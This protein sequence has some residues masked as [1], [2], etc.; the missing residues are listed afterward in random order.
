MVEDHHQIDP[1]L[2]RQFSKIIISLIC[3]VFFLMINT[4]LGVVLDL[5]FEDNNRI[6]QWQHVAFYIWFLLS[7]YLLVKFLLKLWNRNARIRR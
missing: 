4:Y 7:I 3:G 5:G 2:Q 1:D 6:P